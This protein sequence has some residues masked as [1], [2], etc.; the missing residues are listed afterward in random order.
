ML[1][2]MVAGLIGGAAFIAALVVQRQVNERRLL[3]RALSLVPQASPAPVRP[4]WSQIAWIGVLACADGLGAGQAAWIPAHWGRRVEERMGRI[5]GWTPKASRWLGL[6]E[7]AA[8]AAL[9]LMCALGSDLV[10]AGSVALGA[11][12]LPDLWLREQDEHRRR[13]ILAELPDTLDLLAACLEAGLNFEQALGILLERN[14]PHP[15]Y[16]EW[17]CLLREVRMGRSR[18]EALTAMARRVEAP[19]FTALTTA[20]V[21]AER[22]GVPAGAML[23]TQAEQQRGRRSLRVEKL[24]LEAPVK[25]LI[26]LV[27]FIFPVVFLI[28][29]GPVFIR[30]LQG[31]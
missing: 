19:D 1:E 26:P 25:L 7:L 22:L 27:L 28:L 21:Q 29:F 8:G 23:K 17:E 30:F 9:S 15:L 4:A 6:K 14:R 2:W 5:P 13:L 11:F 10:L 12:F 31:F 18:A 20:M 24:A 3:R 16:Q